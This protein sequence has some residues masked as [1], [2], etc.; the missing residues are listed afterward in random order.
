MQKQKQKV[1]KNVKRW[2]L[3]GYIYGFVY[4]AVM[5][6]AVI[7]QKINMALN[8]SKQQIILSLS[9][10]SLARIGNGAM[11]TRYL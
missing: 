6:D 7:L 11:L 10:L 2:D 3:I 5:L 8:T 9:H 1:V 4:H